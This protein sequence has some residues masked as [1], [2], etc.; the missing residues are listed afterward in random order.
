MTLSYSQYAA[1][2]LENILDFLINRQGVAHIKAVECSSDKIFITDIF[3]S[4]QYPVKMK[5]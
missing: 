5:S 3:D 4:R 1:E 2:K